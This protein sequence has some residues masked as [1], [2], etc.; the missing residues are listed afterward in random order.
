[1]GFKVDARTR[2][3]EVQADFPDLKVSNDDNEGTATGTVGNGAVRL[4]LNSEHG[5]IAIRKSSDSGPVLAA[6][7]RPPKPPK[8]PAPPP[9]PTEN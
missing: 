5:A 3:G 1:M 2:G 4:V 8:V 6:P 9:G 7:P